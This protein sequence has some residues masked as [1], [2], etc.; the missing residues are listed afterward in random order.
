MVHVHTS[1]TASL[2][3]FAIS[4][5]RHSAI[6]AL[7]SFNIAAALWSNSALFHSGVLAHDFWAVF[8]DSMTL[9]TS[10]WVQ[11]V[12]YSIK[13]NYYPK[14]TKTKKKVEGLYHRDAIAHEFQQ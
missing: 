8:A 2:A 7:C 3:G 13:V 12:E 6:G 10:S 11:A 14:V 1:V 9:L 4:L 5:I